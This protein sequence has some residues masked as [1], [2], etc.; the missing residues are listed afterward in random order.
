MNQTVPADILYRID[1][2]NGQARGLLLRSTAMAEEGRRIHGLSRTA[3]AA[4]GRLMSM[5]CIMGALL[6]EDKGSVSCI[7][8][9]DGPLGTMI[10]VGR[11]T[12]DVKG[13]VQQPDVELPR[14]EGKLPVGDAVG[15]H[16]T[17][18][19]IK[20]LGFGEP[21]SGQVNLVS[22][23]LG[24][25]FALYFTASEQTPSL[26]SLGV[27]TGDTVQAAG[28]L[29]VQLLPGAL[30]E[31]PGLL[32]ARAP[33]FSHISSLLAEW[34][35]EALIHRLFEG[36]EP[37]VLGTQSVRYACDCSRERVERA[38]ISLGRAELEQLIREQDHCTVDCQFCNSRRA[39]SGQE[40]RALLDVATRP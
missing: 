27:L 22:G 30:Q 21:Y 23:E 38:L 6:K 20:D 33:V 2:L 11:P 25:D 35:D 19:V 36:L 34:G 37:K 17:L 28:G 3:T 24:E 10:A 4:L 18:Q 12:G 16:G 15:R 32:E 9:G 29:L 1:L 5:T 8:R 14:V 13:Y 31:A 26:V 40:L 7:V 39:F